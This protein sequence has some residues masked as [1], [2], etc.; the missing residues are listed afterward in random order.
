MASTKTA[1]TGFK[2]KNKLRRQAAYLN[3]KKTREAEKRDLRHRRK[4]EEDKD[5][6]RRPSG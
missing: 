5:L 2:P 4:R 6:G 1:P 3:I